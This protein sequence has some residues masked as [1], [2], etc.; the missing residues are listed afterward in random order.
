[1]LLR[2]AL[3]ALLVSGCYISGGLGTNDGQRATAHLSAGLSLRLGDRA[4]ARIGG[5]VAYGGKEV[6]PGS[7]LLGTD[8]QLKPLRDGHQAISILGEVAL[9]TG[10]N[11]TY[12]DPEL[13][14]AI[15]RAYAGLGYTI[16]LFDMFSPRSE[17]PR[18]RRHVGS[19]T[20]SAGPELYWTPGDT[21]LGVCADVVYTMSG[22]VFR[23]ALDSKD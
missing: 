13:H 2:G 20:F 11:W 21:K 12:K 9:P 18:T 19:L 16:Q 10:G 17:E 22:R 4:H 15:G 7:V 14:Q 23:D 5:N 6:V 3:C 8:V 1:M